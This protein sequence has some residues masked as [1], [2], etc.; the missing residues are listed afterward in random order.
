MSTLDN[1]T[2]YLEADLAECVK[3][4][5]QTCEMMGIVNPTIV[6]RIETQVQAGSVITS[7]EI[8]LPRYPEVT[9]NVKAANIEAA[10]EEFDHRLTFET[11]S[12]HDRSQKARNVHELPQPRNTQPTLLTGPK[13]DKTN[14]IGADDIPDE[15]PF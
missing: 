9:I 1:T 3:Q 8:T 11:R 14:T 7:Y 4:I 5:H 13:D 2:N 6:F 10:L 12:D 15:I